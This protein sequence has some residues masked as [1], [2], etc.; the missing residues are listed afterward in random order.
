MSRQETKTGSPDADCI[1]RGAKYFFQIDRAGRQRSGKVYDENG[2]LVWRYAARRD[3]LGPRRGNPFT[4]P[5]FVFTEADGPAE[6]VIHKLSCFP[7]GFEIRDRDA[8][9]GRIGVR[10]IVRI[11]WGVEIEGTGSWT[12]SLPLFTVYFHGESQSGRDIWV[13]VGP[14]KMEWSVLI[15]PGINDRRLVVPLAFIHNEWWHYA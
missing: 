8:V 10:S 7:S 13:I 1:D 3:A 14:S 6:L 12:F 4:K 9:I 11:K 2:G 15:R 5:D